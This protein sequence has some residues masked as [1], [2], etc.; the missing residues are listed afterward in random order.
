MSN[1]TVG[2]TTSETSDARTWQLH[3]DPESDVFEPFTLAV[4]AG[5][6]ANAMSVD[7]EDYFQVSAFE[8]H[9][10]RVEWPFWP[11]RVERNLERTLALFEKHQVKATFF[12]LGWVAER[13]PQI[14]RAIVEAGHEL[15]SHGFA[16]D[17]VTQL[18]PYQ[19]RAD[20]ERTK[21]LL[22]DQSGQSV[23]GYRAPSY[24]IGANNLWALKV[25][26][27]T[28]HDYS[29]SIYPVHHDQYGMP[30][31]PRF[32]FRVRGVGLLEVPPTTWRGLRRAWPCAGGGFFRLYPY[33]L[34][35]WLLNRVNT[36]ERQPGVFYFHPWELDPDQP[37]PAGLPPRTR[38]RH[39]LNLHR[40]EPRLEQ[41]LDDFQWQRMDQVFASGFAGAATRAAS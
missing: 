3:A 25:L 23:R 11:A 37:R 28:G 10:P 20:V 35:R 5:P 36:V 16:H 29:S 32:A 1:Q 38:F 7:V 2:V 39:Y 17:R 24:S 15:A 30:E 41:L 26:A 14:P 31:A 19:F 18:D 34:S 6:I 8:G 27:E 40:M 9:V 12:T 22:E 33:R 21:K 4:P 13:W